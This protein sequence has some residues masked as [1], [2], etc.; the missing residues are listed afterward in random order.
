MS[1]TT[2]QRPSYLDTLDCVITETIAPLAVETDQA[3][4]YPR[5]AVEALGKAGLLGLISAQDVGGLGEAHRTATLVIEEIGKY[6]AST[7]MIVCMH[8]AGTAVIEAYG[9]REVREAI[10]AGQHVTTLAAGTTRMLTRTPSFDH[11]NFTVVSTAPAELVAL[12]NRCSSICLMM[13]RRFDL[14][15]IWRDYKRGTQEEEMA[16]KP[17]RRL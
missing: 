9:P 12:F 4:A 11:C 14:C 7:A 13:T 10:A 5:A 15:A 6:C 2:P 1:T 17:L 3:G 8:Y 16:T